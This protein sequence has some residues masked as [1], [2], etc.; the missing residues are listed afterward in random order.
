MDE[1]T[2]FECVRQA[3]DEVAEPERRDHLQRYF[4]TSKGEYGEGD[5]F[6]GVRVPMVRKVA[7]QFRDIDLMIVVK[8]LRSPYHED[9]LTSL[10]IMIDKFDRGDAKL[11]NQIFQLYL[12]NTT[13]INNWDLVDTSAPQVVG[14]YLQEKDRE[15]LINLAKSGVIW[16]RRIAMLS[17]YHFIKQDEFKDALRIADLLLTDKEDLIHKAVGWM[18][19]EIGNRDRQTEEEFLKPRYNQMPRTML[20]YAIEKF[21]P[22]MRKAY[23]NGE[24]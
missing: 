21:P 14:A 12:D 18:L 5:R 9:R 19:R 8:L 11:Q 16:E 22:Q 1:I 20:R 6:R 7:K 4:K 17:T 10:L 23:L 3:L 24:I 15:I 2:R 13:H